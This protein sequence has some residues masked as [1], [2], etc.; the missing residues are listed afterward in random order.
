MDRLFSYTSS[1]E[2]QDPDPDRKFRIPIRQNRSGSDRIRI[3]IR[4][5]YVILHFISALPNYVQVIMR[6]EQWEL[7]LELGTLSATYHLLHVWGGGE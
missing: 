3:Q 1:Y 7:H 4:T 6:S 2:L 5:L